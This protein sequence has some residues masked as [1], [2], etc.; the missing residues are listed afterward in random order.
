MLFLPSHPKGDAYLR[1]ISR[2]WIRLSMG[3]GVYGT[4]RKGVE[5][6]LLMARQMTRPRDAG[7]ILLRFTV[8][9]KRLHI[10]TIVSSELRR[11]ELDIMLGRLGWYFEITWNKLEWLN[12]TK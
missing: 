2:P 8:V 11:T 12:G 9:D 1:S 5:D 4:F 7:E 10:R 6:F 3:P